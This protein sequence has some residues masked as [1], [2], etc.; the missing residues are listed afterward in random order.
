M[1][2][3]VVILCN[4]RKNPYP[5]QAR[6]LEILRGRGILEAK[7]LEAKYEAKLEFHGG[8]RGEYG[9]FLELYIVRRNQMLF[10]IEVFKIKELEARFLENK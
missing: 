1:T 8:G 5:P 6:S 7:I 4:S 9:Y 10:T 2:D 3:Q